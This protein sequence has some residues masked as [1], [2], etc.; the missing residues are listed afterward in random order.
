MC[1]LAEN[2]F[3][4]TVDYV[5]PGSESYSTGPL[6]ICFRDA[7]YVPHGVD[8]FYRAVDHELQGPG[9]YSA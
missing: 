3:Y 2:M 5:L 1:Y 8:K 7:Y 6:T 4:Q 9:L